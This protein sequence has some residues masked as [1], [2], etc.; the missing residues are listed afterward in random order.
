ME[1]ISTMKAFI[2]QFTLAISFLGTVS[3]TPHMME[4]LW[5]GYYSDRV[6]SREY[7]KR[8]QEYYAKETP[9]Q[10]EVRKKNHHYCEML[11]EKK[12]P[13]SNIFEGDNLSKSNRLYISCMEERGSPVYLGN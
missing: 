12:Y 13:P 3:C 7:N 4:E 6:A 1:G 2:K 5:N 11:S 8:E 9:E 10:Q